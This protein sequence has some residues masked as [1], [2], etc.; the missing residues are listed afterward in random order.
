MRDA[1]KRGKRRRRSRF[2][3]VGDG[4][5][6]G[7]IA[8]AQQAEPVDQQHLLEGRA[9][10]QAAIVELRRRRA[11]GPARLRR[12]RRAGHRP[13]RAGRRRPRPH[14]A[15]IAIEARGSLVG[16]RIEVAGAARQRVEQRRAIPAVARSTGC[17]ARRPSRRG[18]AR[19]TDAAPRRRRRL[20]AVREQ[21]AA[22]HR[23][24]QPRAL[25]ARRGRAQGRGAR[26]SPAAARP[27]ARPRRP[28]RNRDRRAECVSLP[29]VNRPA[30]KA[31][32]RCRSPCTWSRGTATSL[33]GWR[34]AF[35]RESS[36]PRASLRTTSLSAAEP[37]ALIR[38]P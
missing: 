6:G 20:R 16:V 34:D 31:S 10:D 12:A 17:R 7:Q 2:D 13:G 29:T 18:C 9:A 37:S 21:P 24:G 1:M 23:F 22:D 5:L 14:Q 30:S 36:E 26:R 35:R 32:P 15:V 8:G 25:L 4:L 3:P 11:P 27:A 33:S 28:Q 38:R 19:P